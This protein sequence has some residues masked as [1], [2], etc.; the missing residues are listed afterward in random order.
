VNK[1][2]QF[3]QIA[4]KIFQQ[5]GLNF[6]DAE[7]AGGWTNAVWLNGGYALRVSKQMNSDIIRREVERAKI[8]PQSV[9]YP[10]N[11]ATGVIDG[12]EW[13]LSERICGTVLSDVWHGLNWQEK[14]KAVRQVYDITVD[15]HSVSAENV[16]HITLDR[17][18]YNSFD[19]SESLADI[20][21]YIANGLF[22]P[23]QGK[24]LCDALMR[25]YEC[26]TDA[27]HV[28][29]HGDITLDNLLWH[30][31]NVVSLLD[32]EHAVIAPK[33]LDIHSLVNLALVPYDVILLADE[34]QEIQD[35]VAEMIT[36]FQPL[37]A[38]QNEKALFIGYNILFRQRFLEFWLENPEGDIQQCDAYQKLLSLSDGSGGYLSRLLSS[39]P[40]FQRLNYTNN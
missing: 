6:A 21:R 37:L 4:I 34:N 28:L 32:F 25:F 12:Y 23:Q 29:C 8:L 19:R 39:F 16:K 5:Y 24:N 18:W 10:R 1:L 20:E 26:K 31:G 35:Y 7:R 36:L 30:D 2:E 13:S 38:K 3:E 22:S 14:A 15:V 11:I 9:G 40:P 27:T 33:Q 17:A